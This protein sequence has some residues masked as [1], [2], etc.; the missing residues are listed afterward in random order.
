MPHRGTQTPGPFVKLSVADE[1]QPIFVCCA[2][3]AVQEREWQQPNLPQVPVLDLVPGYPVISRLLF[4]T[5][6]IGSAALPCVADLEV[7]LPDPKGKPVTSQASKPAPAKKQIKPLPKDP[8][9]RT[10]V[11]PLQSIGLQQV[12]VMRRG[13]VPVL[14]SVGPGLGP[15]VAAPQEPAQVTVSARL[16]RALAASVNVFRMPDAQS[17]WLGA[18]K[19]G[20][21]VAIVSQWQG[22][23]AIMM[24]DGT[25]GYVPQSHVELLPYQVKSV[26]PV[27]APVSPAAPPPAMPQQAAQSP[28]RTV[29]DDTL[30]RSLIEEAYRYLGTP[31][32]YGGNS[33]SGIDCS[34][35][36][37]NCFA[38]KGINLPRRASEQARIGQPVPLAELQPGDR[39]YFSVGKDNDHTGIYLGNGYFI[40]AARSRG[41]VSLDHLSTPLFGNNLTGAR[42]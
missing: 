3:L 26:A 8:P 31:Y 13:G 32:V 34:G 12:G 6:I 15:E 20:Q 38:A 17:P 4:A 27:A 28:L 35:L 29:S 2:F 11:L 5:L 19:Q 14:P 23:W 1:H 40:H 18:L 24:G 10:R 33:E 39:L 37:R 7:T 36:V 42:R 21:Q 41:K 25:Q 30:A 16:G 22:W 9:A